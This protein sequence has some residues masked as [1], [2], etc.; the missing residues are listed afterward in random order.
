MSESRYT[1]L[2]SELEA[3]STRLDTLE[4]ETAELRALCLTSQPVRWAEGTV[5][6]RDSETYGA[7]A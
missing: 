6:P 4:R 7:I 5:T 2:L 3:L 1:D